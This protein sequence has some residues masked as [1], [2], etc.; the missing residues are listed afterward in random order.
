MRQ[1]YERSFD[2]DD[3]DQDDDEGDA[4]AISPVP[5][6]KAR[7]KIDEMSSDRG[8]GECEG[9]FSRPAGCCWWWAIY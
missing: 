4:N 2:D 5:L 9:R 6:R 8:R 3:D 7:R 1:K